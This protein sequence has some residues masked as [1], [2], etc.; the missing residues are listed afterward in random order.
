VHSKLLQALDKSAG[1]SALLDLLPYAAGAGHGEE[2][3]ST[4]R[5]AGTYRKL[6]MLELLE[7]TRL[8]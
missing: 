6:V 5:A 7:W 3:G 8:R 4:H 2:Q 1:E